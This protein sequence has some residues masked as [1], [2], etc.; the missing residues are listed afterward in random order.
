MMSTNFPTNYQE[1]ELFQEIQEKE[2]ADFDSATVHRLYLNSTTATTSTLEK[3]TS[4]GSIKRSSP[5]SFS[6]FQEPSP[7]RA[8]LYLPS[9]TTTATSPPLLSPPPPSPSD[10]SHP[11]NS[12]SDVTALTQP[13]NS[14]SP[15]YSSRICADISASA[16]PSPVSVAASLA[17][18]P[19]PPVTL[20]R[21]HS[22][23]TSSDYQPRPQLAKFPSSDQANHESRV[24]S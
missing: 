23:P 2:K 20:W 17:L 14:H 4:C 22:D 13:M 11:N 19:L 18:P 6:F 3:C 10:A 21:T 15:E 8:T 7:K 1:P 12:R 5:S 24:G 16:S 9:F